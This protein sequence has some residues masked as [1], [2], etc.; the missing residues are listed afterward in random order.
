MSKTFAP[1]SVVTPFI[2]EDVMVDGFPV[3]VDGSAV[4]A[5]GFALMGDG[6]GLVGCMVSLVGFLVDCT[7]LPVNK[8]SVQ[9]MRF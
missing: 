9:N 6:L 8:F 3:M 2:V 7:E 1:S 4:M 5:D